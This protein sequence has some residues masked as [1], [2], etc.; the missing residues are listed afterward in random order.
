M[1]DSIAE[2]ERELKMRREEL[3]PRHGYRGQQIKA[4]QNAIPA[5]VAGACVALRR[6]SAIISSAVHGK[7]QRVTS[8]TSGNKGSE[9]SLPRNTSCHASPRNNSYQV[10]PSSR[11]TKQ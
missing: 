1:L 7:L 3:S 8:S 5:P 11:Q 9:P 2:M 4:I 6:S 10:S